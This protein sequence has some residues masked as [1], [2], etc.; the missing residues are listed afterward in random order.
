MTFGLGR[1][2]L[3]TPITA[4]NILFSSHNKATRN[5]LPQCQFRRQ[6]HGGGVVK[7]DL[8]GKERILNPGFG[9]SQ[10]GIDNSTGSSTKFMRRFCRMYFGRR[11]RISSASGSNPPEEHD[12]DQDGAVSEEVEETETKFTAA[13][14]ETE[15]E[16]EAK[17][18]D[19]AY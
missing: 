12:L 10:N 19:M 5:S 4:R 11:Q 16:A 7:F 9:L 1:L 6:N 8:A 14:A 13:A 2:Y 15:T 18:W 17:V 3:S